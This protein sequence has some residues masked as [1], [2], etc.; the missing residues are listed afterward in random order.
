M[1]TNASAPA[2]P[3]PATSAAGS[4]EIHLKRSLKLW[5]LIIYGIILIQP[6]AGLPLFGVVSDEARGHVVTTLLIA[7]VAM[8]F[9]AVSYGRMAR[10]YPSAGSA[11]TYV[12]REL[13]RRAG[14]LVGWSMMMDYLL[15]PILCVV[16]CSKAAGNIC[17]MV[18]YWAWAIFFVV[19]FTGLNL[20]GIK[21][22]SRTNTW[23]AAAM[24]V[25]VAILFAAIGRY[26]YAHAS[27]A[28]WEFFVRPFYDPATFSF[29][30]LWR[31]T[32]IAVLTYVGFDAISTLSEEVEN[33]RRNILLATVLT[34]LFTGIF[35][36]MQIYAGQLVWPYGSEK[37]PDV[38]TA[39]VFVAGKAGGIWLLQLVNFTLL[40]AS[41]GSGMGAQLASA[42]LLYSMGRD[43]VIPKRF[44]GALNPRTQTPTNNVLLTGA[45]AMIGAFCLSYQLS[46]EMMNFGAFVAFV[47]VNIAAFTHYSLRGRDWRLMTWMPPL[48]GGA[49]CFYIWVH[50]RWPAMVLGAGWLVVG[51]LWGGLRKGGFRTM[52]SIE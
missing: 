17:S 47:G 1:S 33:P 3:P 6:T 26:L 51:L 27:G 25:V 49:I 13:D 50:L 7:M 43:D 22:S 15:C 28:G 30:A 5:D 39:Y 42:R 37:F 41:V 23:L 34:C 24:T 29:P 44:F 18:P 48:V 46:A 32:S 16:W 12:G 19:L 38:D 21:A 36:G 9:T 10:V 45:L 11:F 2:E 52:R 20:R 4:S 8:L 31:G 14:Y 35:S 40:V